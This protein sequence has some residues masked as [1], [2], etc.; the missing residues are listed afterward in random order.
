MSSEETAYNIFQAFKLCMVP[1]S[2]S[3]LYR[4]GHSHHRLQFVISCKE[5]LS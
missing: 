1:N 5:N 4:Q 2:S 3:K